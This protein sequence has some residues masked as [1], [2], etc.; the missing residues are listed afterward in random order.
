VRIISTEKGSDVGKIF[1]R[2]NR[3]VKAIESQISFSRDER[4]GWL[5][6][7]P[8]NL[9]STIRASVHIRLPKLS[10]RKDFKE[11]C[12]KL[13]LLVRGINDE[14]SD[15]KGS[16][17][18]ISNKSRLGISEFEAVS[19]MYNGVKELIRMEKEAV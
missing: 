18:D 8:T 3:G 19:Q 17:Y 10:A 14:N 13:K 1:D 7:C 11:I 12:E 16:I 9:G 4:L 2:L 5:T 6:F 15:S